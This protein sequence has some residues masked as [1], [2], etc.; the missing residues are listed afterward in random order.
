MK[1]NKLKITA[2]LFF[3]S[4]ILGLSTYLMNT[5]AIE[6]STPETSAVSS[7]ENKDAV[8]TTSS[9]SVES[10]TDAAAESTPT[11]EEQSAA[12]EEQQPVPEEERPTEIYTVQQGQNLWEIAQTTE[13]SLQDL[14]NINQLSNSAIFTGQELLVEK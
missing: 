1:K 5:T 9:T 4:G 11:V 13:M 3:F 6:G 2:A 12:S 14:M 10:T 8:V 7:E